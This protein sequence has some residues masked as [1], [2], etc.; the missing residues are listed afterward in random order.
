MHA[1]AFRAPSGG[2]A[3]G[4]RRAIRLP[5]RPDLSDSSSQ[6]AHADGEIVTALLSGAALS[7]GRLSAVAGPQLRELVGALGSGLESSAASSPGGRSLT[8]RGDA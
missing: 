6:S 8:L 4:D 2:L 7:D 3:L 5:A 1:H